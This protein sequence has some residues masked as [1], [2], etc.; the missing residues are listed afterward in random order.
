MLVENTL[1]G[2]VDKVALAIQDLKEHEPP[3]GYYVAFSGGKDS[4]TVLDLVKR[5]G[6][7]FDAFYNIV[8]IEPPELIPFIQKY[9]PEVHLV[10]PEKTIYELIIENEFPPLRQMRYCHRML[11]RGGETR[12]KITGVR[13]EESKRRA[14]KP[15]F[16]K[17]RDGRGYLLHLIHD[18]TTRDVWQYIHNRHIPYCPLYDQGRQR[19][20]CLFCPFGRQDQMQDDLKRYP[21][22]AQQ[23]IQALDI[24]LDKKIEKGKPLKF[25]DGTEFFY[26]WINH[27]RHN[28]FKNRLLP[29]L[30]DEI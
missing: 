27:S 21:Q 10:P 23:L 30:F 28:K 7:K 16:E 9:Y 1:F 5:S 18:W 2:T 22:I 14:Q 24:V 3:E 26:W 15:K 17:T 19:I 8:T 4:V 29:S 20:G 11:K 13:G 25:K 12:I 6:V